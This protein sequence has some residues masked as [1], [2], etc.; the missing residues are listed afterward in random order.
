MVVNVLIDLV[1]PCYGLDETLGAFWNPGYLISPPF[2]LDRKPLFILILSIVISLGLVL[3]P[4]HL[5]S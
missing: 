3:I 5:N 4:G 1:T 2:T